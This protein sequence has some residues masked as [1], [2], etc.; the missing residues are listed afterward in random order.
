MDVLNISFAEELL[1]V[2]KDDQIAGGEWVERILI[3]EGIIDL[4]NIFALEY[5]L[6]RVLWNPIDDV[7]NI[8]V[9]L[10]FWGKIEIDLFNLLELFVNPALDSF[11]LQDFEVAEHVP[12]HL[13]VLLESFLRQF[14]LDF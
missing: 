5:V 13:L 4:E 3:N 10:L 6:G 1:G 8:V 12:D 14:Y 11:F 2:E 7:F 9:D